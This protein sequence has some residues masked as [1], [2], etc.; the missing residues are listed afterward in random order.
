MMRIMHDDTGGNDYAKEVCIFH[1]Q[2]T[3]SCHH[4]VVQYFAQSASQPRENRKQKR[5]KTPWQ[6]LR[7]RLQQWT[8]VIPKIDY[9]F[10]STQRHRYRGV[11]IESTLPHPHTHSHTQ[12]SGKHIIRLAPSSGD[13][14]HDVHSPRT[15]AHV[16]RV[17]APY[18]AWAP[19]PVYCRRR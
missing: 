16:E 3:H 8:I 12:S 13:P 17:N 18:S 2:N 1:N 4:Y 5:L 15:C 9:R 11:P 19:Q 14:K 10:A 7:W 6:V